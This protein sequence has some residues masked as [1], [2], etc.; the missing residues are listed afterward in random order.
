MRMIEL[1]KR[2]RAVLLAC[3]VLGAGQRA[4]FAAS[5][6]DSAFSWFAQLVAFDQTSRTVTAKA[7]VEA[8]VVRYL[9]QFKPG[10]FI[11]L[12]WQQFG[13]EGD[14]VRYVAPASAMAAETGYIVRAQYVSADPT[15]RT[16]TFKTSVPELVVKTLATARPGTPIKVRSS[17]LL[18]ASRSPVAA[19]AL[20][21]TPKPRPVAK[22]DA[23]KD[24]AGANIAGKWALQTSVMNNALRLTCDL[25]QQGK[26]LGGKCG[27]PGP[28]GDV[29]VTGGVDGKAVTLQFEVTSFGPRLVFLHRGE[30]DEQGTTVKGM[31]NMLG[32]DSPFTMSKQ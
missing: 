11:V 30:V 26:K 32:E 22:A 15:A 19:I 21:E 6:S 12:V 7:P 10:E 29:D 18:T 9:G 8:H 31:L 20:N 5:A 3:L 17:A 14:A 25:T 4:T 13:G 27:G 24:A 16:I 28:L 2:L 23:G 1:G